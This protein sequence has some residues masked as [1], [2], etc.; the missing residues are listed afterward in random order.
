MGDVVVPSANNENG[1][2]G[3]ISNSFSDSVTSVKS[4]LLDNNIVNRGNNAISE[5]TKIVS[6]AV[7]N[8]S[9]ANTKEAIVNAMSDTSSSLY[10]III[11]LFISAIVCY[12]LYYIITDNVLYQQRLIV[13]GTEVPVV[14]SELSAFPFKQKLE[15][16][17]GNKRSYCFWIYIF[18][19]GSGAGSF[20]HIAHISNESTNLSVKNASPYILL[21]EDTNSIHVRFAHEDDEFSPTKTKFDNR[22]EILQ[23]KSGKQCGFT[24]KYIPIQRWVHV[25]FVLNDIANG[26]V[27]V[28]LDGNYS[29]NPIES[30]STFQIHKL[31][32]DHTGSLYVGG[33]GRVLTG[34][35]GLLSKFTMFNHD[36]NS[37]DIFREYNAGPLNSIMGKL[38]MGAYG[39]RNPV[40]KLKSSNLLIT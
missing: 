21:D 9:V 28:Y 29:E 25:S 8:V 38:G 37:N 18:N 22:T 11:L 36:I 14:C 16:G 10:L 19:I 35:S 30:S 1:I 34:F 7:S 4:G 5:S 24:I 6:S 31:K 40:Y 27:A 15:S 2:L 23:T 3:N 20:R 33:D 26:S 32:L 39:I 13:P 12:I 17:N